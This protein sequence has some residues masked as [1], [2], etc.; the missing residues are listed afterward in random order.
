MT[1]NNNKSTSKVS[2]PNSIYN[3]L[4]S[5]NAR[6]IRTVLL[7]VQLL[8]EQACVELTNNPT[9]T[10]RSSKFN[11]LTSNKSLQVL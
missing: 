5:V 10:I 9:I 7:I 3:K 8:N 4:Y 11:K 1:K 2:V 6:E